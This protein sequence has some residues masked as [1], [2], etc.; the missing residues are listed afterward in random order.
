MSKR[1][2]EYVDVDLERVLSAAEK[3]LLPTRSVKDILTDLDAL[4]A[5]PA[6]P[7]YP[8]AV[9]VLNFEV[10]RLKRVDDLLR[11]ITSPSTISD[12][13]KRIISAR[14]DFFEAGLDALR[15]NGDQDCPFCRQ[16]IVHSPAKDHIQLYL[17][18]FADAEGR[19]KKEL[20]TAWTEMKADRNALNARVTAIARETLKFEALRKFVPS[21]RNVEITD[22]TVSAQAVDKVLAEYL[23]AIEAKGHSP[24]TETA[25]P[26]SSLE[27]L[28]LHL[29][30]DI[31][32][33]NTI[34]NAITHAVRASDT[35]RKALQRAV[36]LAFET[37]FVH[38]N[39]SSITAVHDLEKKQPM[40]RGSWRT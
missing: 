3:P 2:K 23:S 12:E 24:E 13:I 20:R 6:E 29:N 33:L 22:V 39:W 37:E 1:L 15:E 32:T 4:K 10:E 31:E 38:I 7:D 27:S 30:R 40:L 17:A 5:I 36:C 19:H 21:Q 8:S 18:Y 28:I 9:V 26:S 16:S 14:P 25:I 11:K 34:F 35:E